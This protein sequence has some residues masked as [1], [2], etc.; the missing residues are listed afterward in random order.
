MRFSRTPVTTGLPPTPL[1]L[2]P[3]PPPDADSVK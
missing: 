3:L 2:N 1:N